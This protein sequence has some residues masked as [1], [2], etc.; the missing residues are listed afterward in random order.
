MKIKQFQ[1]T[2]VSTWSPKSNYP[3]N[4]AMGTAAQQLDASFNTSSTLE[5]YTVQSNDITLNASISTD[6]R[7]HKLVWGG[8]NSNEE[9][10]SGIIAAGC[11]NGVIRLYNAS[12]LARNVDS[13]LAKSD[14]HV[15]SV[16][17][18]NFNLFQTNL[19]AS[20][21][22]ESEIF[23]WDLNSMSTPMTPGSKSETLE[24]VIDLA[25]NNEVQHI[26]GSLFHKYTVVW[27]L[28]KNEPII[29]LSES[30]SKVK[31]KAMS[32]NPKVATQVCIASEDDQNPVIQLWDL[33]YASSPVKNLMGHQKGI[34]SMSWCSED[35][36]L[37]IS[38]GKDNRILIWNPSSENEENLLVCELEHNNQWNFEIN[39]CP[40]DP[41]LI[42]TS[43]FDGLT[44]VYSIN[45]LQN[46]DDQKIN[47]ENGNINSQWTKVSSLTN[48][49][50]WLQRNCGAS[51]AFGGYL[52]SFDGSLKAVQLNKTVIES[53][54][55]VWSEHLS[56]IL[57]NGNYEGFCHSKSEMTPDGNNHI[58]WKFL[59]TM[60]QSNPK[61]AQLEILGYSTKKEENDG[62]HSN[63][64]N[65]QEEHN[66]VAKFDDFNLKSSNPNDLQDLIY[67]SLLIGNLST[68]ADL[69]LDNG[70]PVEALLLGI[71]AGPKTLS[72]IQN[73]YL[74]NSKEPTA[75]LLHAIVTND[76]SNLIE[77][78]NLNCWK[79][80]MTAI[81][82]HTNGPSFVSSFEKLGNRLAASD[83]LS[84]SQYAQLC[85]IC[86]GN[87]EALID[88]K[89]DIKTVE[90]LQ[91]CVEMAMM[92]HQSKL[93]SKSNLEVGQKMSELLVMYS[94]TLISQGDL[95]GALRYLEFTNK[96]YS[97]DLKNQLFKALGKNQTAE[98]S[99]NI[100]QK[101][102][103]IGTQD[104]RKYSTSS[105]TGTVTPEPPFPSYP[106]KY[107]Q[108]NDTYQNHRQLPSNYPPHIQSQPT[109]NINNQPTSIYNNPLNS[110]PE[111]GNSYINQTNMQ[112]T[113]PPTPPPDSGSRCMT[114]SSIK[115]GK[116]KY[117]VDPS[118][119]GNNIY[120]SY[121][122]GLGNPLGQQSGFN[123]QMGQPNTLN[124][125]LG[126][127]SGFNSPMGQPQPHIFNQPFGQQSSYN[128]TIGQQS[129]FNPLGGQSNTLNQPL[130]QQSGFNPPMGQSNFINQP[131]EHT[132]N[133]NQHMRPNINDP[134]S[135][136]ISN[137]NQPKSF[138][139]LPNLNQQPTFQPIQSHLNNF[140][141]AIPHSPN[142]NQSS[143]NYNQRAPSVEP[144]PISYM[145]KSTPAGWND[146]P[147]LSTSAPIQKPPTPVSSIPITHPLYT[148]NPPP[149]EEIGT[150]IPLR[151]TN[152]EQYFNN[153]ITQGVEALTKQPI[154]QE[155]VKIQVILDGLQSKLLEAA[156]T[157]QTRK[158]VS[159]IAK[160]LELLYDSLRE[161]S[162]SAYLIQ[163]LH[164]MI[165]LVLKRDYNGAFN[166]HTQLVSGPEFSKISTFM[167]SL[168]AL[169]QMTYQYNVSL[170][171]L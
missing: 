112:K 147:M 16:K 160:K 169:F 56:K 64:S 78:C 14:R 163:C 24:D 136:Q 59:K 5:L 129:N 25:W 117:V 150:Y 126:Q 32:W 50:K 121:N 92:L 74:K 83:D 161:N 86:S 63:L 124:Q 134:A 90:K 72:R 76:W 89:K 95:E 41:L 152:E 157:A 55:L 9:W 39:W 11:D 68:A 26:L 118:V 138:G 57:N 142:F 80:I 62:F 81:L 132:S 158:R 84:L 88:N 82:T 20:G 3:I 139:Q 31:W 91:E 113:V 85:Y 151:S 96:D 106:N 38:C 45:D 154:P 18:L 143:S 127:Q 42:A 6:C 99:N 75:A 47:G 28:R 70:K 109:Y 58:I 94:E 93:S 103:N 111:Y 168:K 33:R 108:D 35:P 171:G 162:L 8:A 155:H 23:I 144:L 7:F 60:F 149:I 61:E 137:F 146:P 2:V 164:T 128:P 69:F 46:S 105:A 122:N 66:I 30:N 130:G 145:K 27:D 29:K 166:I 1:K 67:Q 15:G 77:N 133:L 115:P 10:D 165:D 12:K 37:L 52:V 48:A 71:I 116:P 17:A 4:I 131:M 170:E 110:T 53:D 140:P 102:S 36:D 148:N 40:K 125:P 65:I 97:I 79:E 43:S 120:G 54:L 153:N 104:L 100:L 21:A 141:Q 156:P 49:P 101:T 44:T 119:K 98:N 73:K 159:D 123:T 19:F 167:P 87:V 34:L 51:F 22:S 107:I 135:A 114:P 13:I